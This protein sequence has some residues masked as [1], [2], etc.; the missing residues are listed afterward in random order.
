MK[1][2][3]YIVFQNNVLSR[4]K[5]SSGCNICV[6]NMHICHSCVED[7]FKTTNRRVKITSGGG[8]YYTN[9][10]EYYISTGMIYS[11]HLR[12]RRMLRTRVERARRTQRKARVTK[13][14]LR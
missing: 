1:E 4:G 11:P 2:S 8:A 6:T 9:E 12:Y 13:A 7:L 14:G 3:Q 10:F 5:L